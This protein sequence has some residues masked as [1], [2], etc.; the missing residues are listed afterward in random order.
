MK[1]AIIAFSVLAAASA[2]A[3]L[4]ISEICPQPAA[5]HPTTGEVIDQL[6]PNG[7]VSGW[8]EL[9]NTS[10]TDSVDLSNYQIVRTH[11][12]KKVKDKPYSPAN[13]KNDGP[14]MLPSRTI[15]PGERVL[16][17]TSDEYDNDEEVDGLGLIVK[18][19]NSIIVL[20]SKVN[21]KR[22]PMI[23][24]YDY[25]SDSGVVVDR[26]IIPVDLPKGYAFVP[27]PDSAGRTNYVERTVVSTSNVLERI[28]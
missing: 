16:V 19:Y 8:I 11:R 21:P 2:S 12:G 17:Y 10:A 23:Q 9:E 18:E 26:F 27:G 1:Q 7:K 3:Q 13:P 4:R 28:Q 5:V 14:S 24:L 25:T 15:G 6:D 22:F 20:P